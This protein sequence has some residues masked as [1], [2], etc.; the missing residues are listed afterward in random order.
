SLPPQL[1]TVIIM[2]RKQFPVRSFYSAFSLARLYSWENNVGQKAG[3]KGLWD[4]ELT[5]L[6]RH[7]P[8]VGSGLYSR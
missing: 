4:K 6:S 3:G 2:S 5:S 7:F 1:C 8:R